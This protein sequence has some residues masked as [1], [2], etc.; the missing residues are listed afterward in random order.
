MTGQ[1]DIVDV[2]PACEL[3]EQLISDEAMTHLQ[4][5]LLHRSELQT[6]VVEVHP[7]RCELCREIMEWATAA[8]AA[9]R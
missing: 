5:L 6:M 3:E 9:R 8:Q 4:L 2:Q 1:S 7:K